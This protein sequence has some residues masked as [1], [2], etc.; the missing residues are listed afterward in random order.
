MGVREHGCVAVAAVPFPRA[1]MYVRISTQQHCLAH[2]HTQ[3]SIM[4]DYPATLPQVRE[5]VPRLAWRHGSVVST[6]FLTSVAF[7]AVFV[8]NTLL[9][10]G[11]AWSHV[12]SQLHVNFRTFPHVPHFCR[13]GIWI[14]CL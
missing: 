11:R 7:T 3:V 12:W 4:L 8:I 5:S 6:A 13:P 10:G 2:V 14:R 9:V 1:W